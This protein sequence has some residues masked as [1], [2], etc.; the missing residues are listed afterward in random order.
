[1]LT[2]AQCRAA[3]A[4]EKPYELTC[5]AVP[6]F[7]LRVL[8]SGKKAFFVRYRAEGKD[9]RERL[10]LMGDDFTADDARRMALRILDGET[11]ERARGH[12]A[13]KVRAEA[14]LA[15]SRQRVVPDEAPASPTPIAV[16]E[17]L[18]PSCG[19]MTVRELVDRFDREHI[20]VR[21]KP[22]TAN[23]YRHTIRK[24]ILPALGQRA[25]DS[26]R[27]ADVERLHSS[28]KEIPGVANYTL[29]VISSMYTRAIRD[30]EL[31]GGANPAHRVPKFRIDPVERFLTPE[32]RR[33]IDA[34]IR[35][36][37]A[38]PAGRRGH[39]EQGAAWA[40]HLLALTAMR[41]DEVCGLEWPMVDWR[42]SCLRLPDSKTGKKVV[43]VSSAVLSLL[44]EIHEHHDNPRTGLVV[45]SRC[46]GRLKGLNRTWSG[47][48]ARAG[49]PDVRLHDLRHSAASDA[50][51]SGVPLQVVGKMLGHKNWQTT[52]RYAH[53]ADHVVHDAVELMSKTILSAT[54]GTGGSKRGRDSRSGGLRG[55]PR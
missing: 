9:R 22:S 25:I 21:L 38:T 19:M 16:P 2:V 55:R 37:R 43:P 30:W 46:G 39:I 50:I 15:R 10:G 11:D 47:I 40:I 33:A 31:M 1:M 32:E 7:L 48:R 27:H 49:L 36:G 24:H 14:V 6:G 8:P 54:D 29:C 52:Q 45:R 35:E 53:I 17:V 26:V 4:R 34:V 18:E 28:L 12:E 23:I 13:G 51:M 3:K 41:R 42:T 20:A 44:R 5:A